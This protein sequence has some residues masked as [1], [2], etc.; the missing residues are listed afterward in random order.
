MKDSYEKLANP[1]EWKNA[2]PI[3]F[4]DENSPRFKIYTG[5][6][7]YQSI[8]VSNVRFL[9]ELHKYQPDVELCV[10]NKKHASMILQYF[11]GTKDAGLSKWFT[12]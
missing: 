11:A 6:K 12:D 4:L 9:K 7:T 3:Y 10:L 1:K 8:K 5:S 2:S